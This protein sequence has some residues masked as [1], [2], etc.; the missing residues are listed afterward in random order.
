M[1]ALLIVFAIFFAMIFSACNNDTDNP[2]SGPGGVTENVI[3]QQPAGN[4][5]SLYFTGS[6]GL[7]SKNLINGLMLTYQDSLKFSGEVKLVSSLMDMDFMMK[8][9]DSTHSAGDLTS[10]KIDTLNTNWQAFTG[11]TWIYTTMS[12]AARHSFFIIRDPNNN[13][14]G[15]HFTFYFRNL[16]IVKY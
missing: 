9:V 5:D 7:Y 4:V 11:Y 13:Y 15:I 16:K 8:Y 2:V 12:S 1:K 3:Y 14:S 10:I 6:T